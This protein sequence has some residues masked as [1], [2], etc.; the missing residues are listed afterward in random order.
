MPFDNPTAYPVSIEVDPSVERATEFLERAWRLIDRPQ[1]WCRGQP[2]SIDGRRLCSMTALQ[3][4]SLRYGPNPSTDSYF[5]A[6]GFLGIAMGGSI[7]GF[8]DTRTH[9]EL[10]DAWQRAIAMS[11]SRCNQRD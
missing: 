11:Q 6:L 1:K 5:M 8:N 7:M 3:V 4:T 9:A 2:E 10:T